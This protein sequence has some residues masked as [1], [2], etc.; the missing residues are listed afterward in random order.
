MGGWPVGM[1][2]VAAGLAL[3]AAPALAAT[4]TQESPVVT[5]DSPGTKA[6]TLSVCNGGG[7]TEV[8]V[9]VVVLDP[10]PSVVL[11]L[12]T[13]PL[14]AEGDVVQL[15]GDGAGQPTLTFG[16]RI[17]DALGAPVAA[18]SGAATRWDTTGVA[19]G[20]YSV[21]LDVDNATGPTATSP[22]SLVTV[23]AWDGL[24]RDGFEIG[25]GHWSGGSTP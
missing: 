8:T 24:F 15:C 17:L 10:R 18:A 2:R 12:V 16:W 19:A 20:V 6:V 23:V 22:P 21:F 3:M 5:F 9:D 14:V 1:A 25:V 4:S 13:P 7:C 11:A